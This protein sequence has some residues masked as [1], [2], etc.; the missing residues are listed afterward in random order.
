LRQQRLR[1]VALEIKESL[2]DPPSDVTVGAEA[3]VDRCVSGRA[4]GL[5]SQL[6][7]SM[8]AGFST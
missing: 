2:A 4:L 1:I 8:P 3:E 5:S 7:L 6:D